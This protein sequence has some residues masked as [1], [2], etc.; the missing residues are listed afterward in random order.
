M[1]RIGQKKFKNGSQHEEDLPQKSAFANPILSIL[2]ILSKTSFGLRL[3]APG[4]LSPF[5]A[6]ASW[7]LGVRLLAVLRVLSLF[8]ANSSQLLKNPIFE[9]CA[10]TFFGNHALIQIVD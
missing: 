4:V 7:R 8:V 5:L 9:R 3:A 6:L 10:L 2:F 1:N